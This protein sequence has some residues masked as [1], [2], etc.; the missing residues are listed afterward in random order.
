MLLGN[1]MATKT[2]QVMTCIY[3][4]VLTAFKRIEKLFLF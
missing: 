3:D 2:L 1:E 4:A